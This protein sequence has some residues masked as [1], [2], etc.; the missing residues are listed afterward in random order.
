MLVLWDRLEIACSGIKTIPPSTSD[1]P[2]QDNLFDWKYI[3]ERILKRLFDAP[4]LQPLL[5]FASESE[6][7]QHN[8]SLK[9]DLPAQVVNML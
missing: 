1:P 4:N 7:N 2:H 8:L 6:I 9:H 5:T 3:R